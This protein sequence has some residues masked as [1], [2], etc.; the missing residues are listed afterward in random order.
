MF[1]HPQSKKSVK[2]WYKSFKE[3]QIVFPRQSIEDEITLDDVAWRE[4]LRALH[5]ANHLGGLVPLLFRHCLLQ[6][7]ELSRKRSHLTTVE[8]YN[9]KS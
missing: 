1:I 5:R 8:V 4:H 7:V 2:N 3:V 9:L 6:H